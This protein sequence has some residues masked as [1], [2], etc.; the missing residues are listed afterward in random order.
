EPEL[1]Q[2][3]GTPYGDLSNISNAYRSAVLRTHHDVANIRGVLNQAEASDIIGLIALSVE[4]ASRI[5]IIDR[6]LLNDG[7][8]SEVVSVEFCRVKE[9]LILHYCAAETGIVSDPG[10]LLVLTFNHPVFVGL[11][12]LRR[13][14]GTLQNISIYQSR[15][16][17]QRGKRGGYTLRIGHLAEPLKHHLARKVVIGAI[18]ECHD[19]IGQAVEGDRAHHGHLRNAVHLN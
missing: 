7:W 1:A 3:G 2:A 8:H 11:Q 9:Y 4:P 19:D 12:F 15:W 6:Q 14:V 16:T 13:A 18:V 17:C 10:H 5:G